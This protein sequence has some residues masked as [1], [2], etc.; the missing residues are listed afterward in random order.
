MLLSSIFSGL[1]V[2]I[3]EAVKLSLSTQSIQMIG[4]CMSS[5]W[6]VYFFQLFT[7]SMK[8]RN[9][10]EVSLGR[11]NSI[12]DG[13]R[14][15]LILLGMTTLSRVYDVF[16]VFLHFL[17]SNRIICRQITCVFFKN[18]NMYIAKCRIKQTKIY[19]SY[20]PC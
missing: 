18:Q 2:G 9:I 19:T 15:L 6:Y 3:T 12:C 14:Y 20:Q 5:V 7:K 4:G 13:G 10:N 17:S 8:K 11:K 1:V 16:L